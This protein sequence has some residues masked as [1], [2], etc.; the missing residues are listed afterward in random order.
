MFLVMLLSITRTISIAMPFHVISH[1]KVI[2]SFVLMVLMMFLYRLHFLV[3]GFDV[4]Y[5][6]QA[7]YCVTA[8]TANSYTIGYMVVACVQVG[9]PSLLIFISFIISVQKLSQPALSAASQEHNKKASVTVSM[10]TGLFLVCNLPIFVNIA[11][12]V[13]TIAFYTYPGP[14]YSS[15]FMLWYS[16]PLT[17]VFSVVLNA[18][19][20]PVLYYWCMK[21]FRDWVGVQLLNKNL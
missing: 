15:S 8:E 17:D 21:G 11:L 19:L 13:I 18:T 5:E 12:Y 9:V 1:K 6:R 20:N 7:A 14:I 16:W 4:E 3:W 10:F 2:G